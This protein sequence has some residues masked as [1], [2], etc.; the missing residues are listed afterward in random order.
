[1]SPILASPHVYIST[2]IINGDI[3]SSWLVVT[4]TRLAAVFCKNVCYL[5]G[6]VSQRYLKYC[7]LGYSPHFA[8]NKT[9]LTTLTF[10]SFFFQL[11][12]RR[13]VERLRERVITICVADS[14]CNLFLEAVGFPNTLMEYSPIWINWCDC[15]HIIL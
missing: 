14:G 13:I 12:Q 2:K 3:C 6:A 10:F 5:F 7:L 1:M 15:K 4:F 8:P 9:Q 11:T